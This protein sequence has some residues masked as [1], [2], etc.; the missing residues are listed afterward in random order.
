VAGA[1][2]IPGGD[3][4]VGTPA[5][6]E[7]QEFLWFGLMFF[8][9]GDGPA[10][11]HAE[12]VDGENIGAAEAEHQEHFHGPGADAADGGQALDEFLIGEF[13]RVIKRGDYAFDC[14]FCEIF[15]C[16]CFCAGE[17]GLAERLFAELEYFLGGR[18]TAGGAESFYAAENGGGSFTGD[19]LISDGFEESFVGTLEMVGVHLEGL[20]FSDEEFQFFVALGERFHRIREIKA[21]SGRCSGHLNSI[22]ETGEQN[23][24]IALLHKRDV[25]V[26]K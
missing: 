19:G 8:A 1:P 25:T 23:S 21:R 22:L 15:H 3:G 17:A 26:D 2:H 10:F 24:K 14:F 11:L 7:C 12:V 6:A 16:D 20:R 4:A 9:V 18:R 5:F 13:L